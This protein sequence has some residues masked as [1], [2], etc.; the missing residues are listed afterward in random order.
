MF[1][2]L[3]AVVTLGGLAIASFVSRVMNE[4]RERALMQARRDEQ[5]RYQGARTELHQHISHAM[6]EVS[7][8]VHRR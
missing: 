3:S 6:R 8:E 2:P 4:S 5:L 1:D 7:A